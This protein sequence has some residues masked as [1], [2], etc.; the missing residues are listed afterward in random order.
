MSTTAPPPTVWGI[1][2]GEHGNQLEIFNSKHGPFP[3]RKGS[4]GYIAIGW[5]AIGDLRMFEDNYI[6]YISKFRIVYGDSSERVF[7]TKANMPWNF[8]FE[9]S[10]GD[11]AICPCAA[12]DLLLIGEIIGDYDT[13]YHGGLELDG[14]KRP[15]FVHIRQVVWQEIIS[16]DDER[17]HELNRIGQLTVSRPKMPFAELQTVLKNKRSTAA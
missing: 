7:K 11:W 12:N 13:D 5:P 4:E 3:P 16:Y 1:F 10:K 14:K 8:A 6:D 15:D 9:M 2:V 17:Y